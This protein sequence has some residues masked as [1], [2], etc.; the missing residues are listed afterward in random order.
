MT[1][2]DLHESVDY[3]VPQQQH[4]AALRAMARRC[5]ADT[6][7]H[8]YDAAPFQQFLDQVYADHGPMAKDLLDPCIDWLVAQVGGEI[9]GYAKLRPLGAPAPQPQEGALELQQIY[10]LQPWHGRGIAEHLMQW[11][12]QRARERAAP[13]L[14]LTVFDHNERAKR[15]YT[16]HG[17]VEVGRCTF[18]LGD[19]IDDDRVWLKT[20]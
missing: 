2:Q 7:A 18:Q 6:F 19:R 12:V 15:F 20:L 13:E 5:F 17:F 11:A 9:V 1:S 16:R 3:L 14:Y 8:L 10:V 4:D